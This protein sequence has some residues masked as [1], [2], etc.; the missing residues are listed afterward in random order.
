MPF[1]GSY[2]TNNWSIMT[3]SWPIIIGPLIGGVLGTLFF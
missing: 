1:F 2:F 3:Q